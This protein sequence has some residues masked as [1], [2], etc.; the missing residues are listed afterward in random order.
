MTKQTVYI[1]PD[2]EDYTGHTTYVLMGTS[3][4]ELVTFALP[5][6]DVAEEK[7][8]QADDYIFPETREERFLDKDLV[9][10]YRKKGYET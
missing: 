4:T 5:V 2:T 1:L 7:Q 8:E 3:T 6:G 9:E 10:F